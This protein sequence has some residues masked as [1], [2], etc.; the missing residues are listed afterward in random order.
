MLLEIDDL[1]LFNNAS[2]CWADGGCQEVKQ[3]HQHEEAHEQP[4][5]ID[6]LNIQGFGKTMFLLYRFDIP[7]VCQVSYWAF[8]SS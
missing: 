5:E 3:D 6:K 7:N 2:V 4:D 8:K 1:L